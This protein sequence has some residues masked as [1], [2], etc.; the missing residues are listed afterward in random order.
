MKRIIGGLLVVVIVGALIWSVG[1]MGGGGSGGS[2]AA[3]PARD[4]PHE[5]DGEHSDGFV[6]PEV[7]KVS[8]GEDR[9]EQSV[10]SGVEAEVQESGEV[11]DP[12][13]QRRDYLLSAHEA[14]LASIAID[15]DH[16]LEEEA[17]AE[18]MFLGRCVA[19]IL[20]DEG[21]AETGDPV[22]LKARGGFALRPTESRWEIAVDQ[23]KYSFPKGEFPAYDRAV[24]RFQ[25]LSGGQSVLEN[26]QADYLEVEELF[27]LALATFE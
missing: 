8:V 23:A 6:P 3:A 14:Y 7:N 21:R 24:Q 25:L 20:F 17:H 1:D 4:Q 5:R 2:A 18:M 26:T 9:E 22:T 16:A 15:G 11:E 19:A 27:E 13:V 12:D 10:T